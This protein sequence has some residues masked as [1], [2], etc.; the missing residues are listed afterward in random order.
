MNTRPQPRNRAAFC[1]AVADAVSAGLVT[2]NVPASMLVQ[3]DDATVTIRLLGTAKP[4]GE[5]GVVAIGISN[6]YQ[7]Y[8]FRP[9]ERAW[10][11]AVQCLATIAVQTTQTSLYYL[12]TGIAPRDFT[13]DRSRLRVRLEPADRYD[14]YPDDRRPIFVPFAGAPTVQLTVVL[15]EP[16]RMMTVMPQ[17]LTD[18][19]VARD[20]VEQVAL[21]NTR[22]LLAATPPTFAEALPG[23]DIRVWDGALVGYDAARVSFPDLLGFAGSADPDE[24]IIVC[25]PVRDSCAVV[26]GSVGRAEVLAAALV[27][28]FDQFAQHPYE[29][30]GTTIL[31]LGADGTYTAALPL[32]EDR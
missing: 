18:W 27:Y 21:A 12:R 7:A 4:D 30:L 32:P 25:A 13:T 8:C 1:Q 28:I 6:Q 2:I 24:I 14:R 26:R 10:L 17:H 23:L 15:D 31:T 3:P 19:G 11:E 29:A 9:S 20:V 5:D 22:A 16:D